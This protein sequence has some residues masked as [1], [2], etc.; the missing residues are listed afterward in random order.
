M[1]GNSNWLVRSNVEAGEG[2]ADI[3]I[4]PE[5]P[6]AGIIFELKHARVASGLNKSCENA[7]T[8]IRN[9]RYEEYLKNDG[10]NKIVLY[11]IAF[12]KKRCKVVVERINGERD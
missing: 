8:Q 2:F 3:I 6:D 9:R 11:G 7:I 5:D 4:E 1:A 12:Y 10:R